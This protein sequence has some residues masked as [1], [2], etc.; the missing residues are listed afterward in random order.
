MR[1][2]AAR[3]LS[4]IAELYLFIVATMCIVKFSDKYIKSVAIYVATWETNRC[5]VCDAVRCIVNI[6]QPIS[7][8]MLIFMETDRGRYYRRLPRTVLRMLLDI[9]V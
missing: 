4:A 3:G 2:R 7:D 6:I 5:Q 8:E 1:H 9:V